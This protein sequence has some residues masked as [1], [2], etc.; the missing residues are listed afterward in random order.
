[1]KPIDIVRRLVLHSRVAT[2]RAGARVL[3]T[4]RR[5]RALASLGLGTASRTEDPTLRIVK[6]ADAL[7]LAEALVDGVPRGMVWDSIWLAHAVAPLAAL[8]YAASVMGNGGGITWVC[9]AAVNPDDDDRE[10]SWGQAARICRDWGQRDRSAAHL[11]S[12]ALQRLELLNARQRLLI[13]NTMIAALT[14][15]Q[16]SYGPVTAR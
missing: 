2:T 10:P 1:M 11:F 6:P 5:Q 7:G 4:R 12:D 14:P 15:L 13:A 9:Q 8:L 3:R 16:T